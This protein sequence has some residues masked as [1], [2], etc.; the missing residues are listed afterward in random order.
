MSAGDADQ[1]REFRLGSSAASVSS[2]TGS[3]DSALK[4]LHQRPALLQDLSWS[5]RYSLKRAIPDVDP[6]R[7]M[8]FSF[9]NDQLFRITVQY[10]QA[11]TSGLTGDDMIA[12]LTKVY[13]ERLIAKAPRAAR[14][15]AS[16]SPAIDMLAE[17]Q[18]GDTRVTLHRSAYDVGFGLVVLSV[19]LEGLARTA[20]ANAVVLDTRESPARE[21]ALLKK[22]QDD[23][24]VAEE[25][26]RA[27]NKGVFR[28]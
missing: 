18:V 15:D 3:N 28:P 21:A 16:D 23:A 19:P 17:W 11:R 25:K 5:P 27:T 1:Y 9:Y 26:A 2:L 6:V 8:V 14:R 20:A 7:E 24:K 12:A 4:T 22:Q 13:G 10:D